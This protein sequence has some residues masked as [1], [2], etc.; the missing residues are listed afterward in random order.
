VDGVFHAAT[1]AA[2]ATA[3]LW[4]DTTAEEVFLLG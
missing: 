3:M 1:A 2:V 4:V